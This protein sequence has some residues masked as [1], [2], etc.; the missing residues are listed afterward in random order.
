[1][2]LDPLLPMSKVSLEEYY[3]K[4][5]GFLKRLEITEFKENP[6]KHTID[7]P[8]TLE[9]DSSDEPIELNTRILLTKEG[10]ILIKCLLMFNDQIPQD[11]KLTHTLWGVLLQGNFEYPEVTY[12][13]DHEYNV[14]VETDMPLD[15]TYENFKSEYDSI[16][17]GALNYFTEI[18]PK[19]DPQ[20]ERVNTF[21]RM[22]HLYLFKIKS[23]IMIHEYPFKITSKIE[24]QLV[25]S[26]LQGL[27]SLIREITKTE[28][29]MKIIEQEGMTILL[30]HGNY[31]TGALLSEK[32]LLSLRKK[33]KQLISEVEHFYE[34]QLQ[35]FSGEIS[36]F[37]KVR[38]LTERI[39]ES[40]KNK[41]QIQ[42]I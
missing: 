18:V 8:L 21:E 13:L 12:S 16:S 32:N 30:E 40:V 5:K 34:E 9:F 31:I 37:D 38:E 42:K 41:E 1:M 11:A 19:V 6:E 3:E 22:H 28:T 7:V 33:L 23:G 14:F 17:F 10:W 35:R 39:F 4:I 26:S 2:S 36:K 20:I 15:T 24:P 29:K 25:S 27:G